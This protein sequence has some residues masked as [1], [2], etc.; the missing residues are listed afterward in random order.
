[1]RVKASSPAPTANDRRPETRAERVADD[2]PE[3]TEDSATGSLVYRLVDVGT[4]TV[5][6]QTPS[7][8]KLKLRAYIDHLF[9]KKSDSTFDTT[10]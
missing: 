8:A 4:G 1:M 9:S 2:R 6:V 5:T 3:V 10:A 7:E